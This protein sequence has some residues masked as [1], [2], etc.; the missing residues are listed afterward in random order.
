M[1]QIRKVYPAREKLPPQLRTLANQLE[2]K[3]GSHRRHGRR[4]NQ[5]QGD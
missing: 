2:G 3:I 1:E 5:G 4:S